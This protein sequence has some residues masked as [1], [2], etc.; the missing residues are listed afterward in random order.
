MQERCGG[1]LPGIRLSALFL[2]QG[3][4]TWSVL[5]LGIVFLGGGKITVGERKA[6]IY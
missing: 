5:C 3:C 4:R 2:S 1:T 6:V